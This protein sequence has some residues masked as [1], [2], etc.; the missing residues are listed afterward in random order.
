MIVE[1]YGGKINFV[2]IEN[3]E[4]IFDF[5]FPL[6]KIEDEELKEYE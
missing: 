3:E 2:S 6:H 5:T 4:T 1:K